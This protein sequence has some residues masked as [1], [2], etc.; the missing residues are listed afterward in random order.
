MITPQPILV[1]GYGRSGASMIAGV[2]NI[3]G[4]F[5]G[6]MDRHCE[7]VQVR[8]KIII[9][10]LESIQV[11]PS[12]QHPLPDPN[13]LPIPVNWGERVFDLIKSDGYTGGPWMYKGSRVCLTWPVWHYAF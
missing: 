11:D 6:V 2:L 8:D 3:C 5:G 9:P 10:Y 7:N 13:H 1:T 12:G 4:A